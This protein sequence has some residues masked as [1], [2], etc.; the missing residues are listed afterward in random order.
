MFLHGIFI[1]CPGMRILLI[2]SLLRDIILNDTSQLF[3]H[4]VWMHMPVAPIFWI[5]IYDPCLSNS[6]PRLAV[7]V[8][9]FAMSGKAS[10]IRDLSLAHFHA[11]IANVTHVVTDA[12]RLTIDIPKLA[13]STHVV[14]SPPFIYSYYRISSLERRVALMQW[15]G[16]S[17]SLSG[18]YCIVYGSGGCDSSCDRCGRSWRYYF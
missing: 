4:I 17:G 11:V 1:D 8:P 14:I 18:Q 15:S 5:R 2:V 9:I 7:Q 16:S 13:H 6:V 10:T 3:I 12:M